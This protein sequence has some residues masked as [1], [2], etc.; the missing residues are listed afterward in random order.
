MNANLQ[1]IMAKTID[2]NVHNGDLEI[3]EVYG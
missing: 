1:K 3:A 2:G